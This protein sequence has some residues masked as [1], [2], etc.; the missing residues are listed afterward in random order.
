MSISNDLLRAI[1]SLDAYNRGYNTRLTDLLVPSAG[2]GEGAE[3]DSRA[4]F[5]ATIV[6]DEPREDAVGILDTVG[7]SAPDASDLAMR[8]SQSLGADGTDMITSFAGQVR[9]ERESQ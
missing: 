4:V 1:L 7:S 5:A 9:A 3:D 8:M 2:D 6:R